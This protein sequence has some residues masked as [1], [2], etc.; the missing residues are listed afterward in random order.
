MDVFTFGE[1][2]IRLS[3]PDGLR[4]ETAGRFEAAVGGSE[5]NVAL[6]LARLGKRAMWFSHLPDHPLGAYV[7]NTLRGYGVDVSAVRFVPGERMGMYYLESGTPPRPA[8][9]WYDRAGS[10]ASKIQPDD[11]PFDQIRAAR[12]LHLTGITPALS[13]S[14]AAAI[15]TALDF[16]K[17]NEI[18]TSFD[19]NYRAL[20]WSPAEAAAACAP[21]C[22]MADVVFI[23]KRDALNLFGEGT[24]EK[25]RMAWGGTVVVTRGAD[26]A[27]ACD[28]AETVQVPALLVTMV[29][30]LGAGDALAAGVICKLLED[31]PLAEALRFGCASAALKLT[32]P[33]D[34][35]IYSRAEVEALVTSGTGAILR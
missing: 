10:A 18:R 14:C 28:G 13:A 26:G 15:R 34:L 22:A 25:L 20:L 27:E 4:I 2:M 21:L 30:R 31:A 9:V 17:A 5:S 3:P 12:W 33:G 23:A 24:A 29:D 32:I 35:A 1:T 16:A 19:V 11:L 7:A 6:A 8:R